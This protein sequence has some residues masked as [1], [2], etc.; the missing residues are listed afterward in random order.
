[1]GPMIKLP[2]PSF[3]DHMQYPLNYALL[4]MLLTIPCIIAGYKFYTIGFKSLFSGSPNM[5]SLIAVGTSAAIIYSMFSLYKIIT[6]DSQYVHYLYFESAGV[7]ITLI[8]LGKTLESVSKDKTSEAIKKL[9]G[10]TPKTAIVVEDGKEIEIPIEEVKIDDIILVKPGSK[11]PVDGEVMEGFTS[12]DE[13]MLTGESIPIEKKV[14]DKVYAASINKNGTIKF[15]AKK[16]GAD[17]ALAQIVKLVEEAQGTKAPIAKLADTIS[18][19]FVPIV[20]IIAIM[21]SL[22]WLISG[23]SIVFSL[24]IFVAVLVIACP[25]AL[26]LATPTAIMVGTGKGAQYGILIKGGEAL[27]TTYKIDTIMFDKTGTVTEGNPQVT[28]IVACDNIDKNKLLQ[29]AA[30]AEKGSEHPLGGAIVK[31]AEKLCIEMLEVNKFNNIPGH[32]IEV[33]I[34]DMH[35][36]LGNE[37]LMNC[38]GVD[39]GVAC[40]AT[41]AA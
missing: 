4:S 15:I 38:R 20:I 35:V 31:N 39:V 18:G 24:T 2:V 19:Y 6:G 23:Q 14:G 16:V 11:I 36:L 32:G 5:D 13:S 26:G 30:S 12:I 22:S 10:L 34:E 41:R 37:K 21:A 29:I 27:E 3:F 28:D 9:M 7:I 33:E 25:C 17:T 1:M 40:H 8:L